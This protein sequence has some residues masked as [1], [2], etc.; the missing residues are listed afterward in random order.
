[1][2]KMLDDENVSISTKQERDK[3]VAR[4][5]RA[6]ANKIDRDYTSKIADF[7]P[8]DGGH[9]L[10]EI[11]SIFRCKIYCWRRLSSRAPWEC[12]RYSPFMSESSY[13]TIV[14]IIIPYSEVKISLQNVGLVLDVDTE[15]P[16]EKRFKR[17]KWTLFESLA[18]LK[19]PE[20]RSK[21][22]DLRKETQ[23]LQTEW[24]R[25]SVHTIDSKEFKKA[26]NA[27]LQIWKKIHI[28]EGKVERI[29]TSDRLGT[30]KLIGEVH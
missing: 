11:E 16:D 27:S 17:Q 20:L 29:K 24:G 6:I 21:I 10:Q 26:F 23:K 4:A 9:K 1:M 2:K 7:K 30:P 3:F 28:N 14:D 22:S 19:K 15:F 13:D 5:K 12:I 25:D 8:E 18:I